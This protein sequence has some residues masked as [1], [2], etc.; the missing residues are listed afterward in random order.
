MKTTLTDHEFKQSL[1]SF[2]GTENWYKVGI[3]PKVLY[4]DGAKYVADSFGAYWFLDTIASH[5][6]EKQFQK[7]EFQV[8][9]LAVKDNVGVLTCE[10]GNK[11]VI[12]TK[13]IPYTDFPFPELAVWFTDNVILLP[14]EY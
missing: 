11:N 13:E 10:D 14:S 2:T 8:W 5:Q 4:T 12:F 7:E 3:N 9:K 6:Y 1:S